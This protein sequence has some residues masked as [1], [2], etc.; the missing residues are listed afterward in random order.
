MDPEPTVADLFAD[1]AAGVEPVVL[2]VAAAG[3][4]VFVLLV[5]IGIGLRVFGKFGVR[6]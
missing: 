1:I 6:R 5:A 3:V 2:T 4:G